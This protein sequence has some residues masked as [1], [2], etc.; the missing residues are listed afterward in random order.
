MQDVGEAL[1][2][3]AD[4]VGLWNEQAVD[5]DR[6]G[7]HRVAAHLRDAVHV[8]LATVQ[9]GVEDR[10]AVGRA[11]AVFQLGGARQQHDLV[12]HLSGRGPDFLPLHL[13]PARDLLRKGLDGGGVQAG[14]RLGETERALVL[15]LHE[16]GQPALALL[17]RAQ[18]HDR[19]RPKQVDVHGG[20]RRHGA[21]VAR[22][23][24][25]HDRGFH[26]TQARATVLGRHRDAQPPG[27][28]HRAVEL[29]RKLAVRVAREPVV[30]A[31]RP[32]HG[33]HA[34]ADRAVVVADGEIHA[35]FSGWG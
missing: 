24:V 35:Q 8:D 2:F 5:E 33:A 25:H 12:R 28:G 13:V 20:R 14:V 19:V 31:K 18:H 16:R 27:A 10:D 9:V 29:T 6:V 30:I 17:G 32:H 15:A 1:A 11:F 21:A 22:H 4:A 34:F 26:D 7:V 23:F 3:F